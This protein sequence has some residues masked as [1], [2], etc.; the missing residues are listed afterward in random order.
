MTA[1]GQCEKE[2]FAIV[3]KSVNGRGLDIKFRWPKEFLVL[4]NKSKEIFKKSSHRGSIEVYFVEKLI[5]II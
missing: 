3:V 4:E 2:N 1:I 5:K